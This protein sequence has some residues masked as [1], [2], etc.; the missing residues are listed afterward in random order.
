MK[1]SAATAADAGL[2]AARSRERVEVTRAQVRRGP[3][4]LRRRG[5]PAAPRAALHV[6]RRR[7][8]SRARRTR[9]R[10]AARPAADA[11]RRRRAG[12]LWRARD[13]VPCRCPEADG[14]QDQLLLFVSRAPRR[15][16]GGPSSPSGISAGPSTMRWTRRR[17]G[18]RAD[19][20]RGRVVLARGA[21]AML[22]RG[23]R[24]QRRRAGACSR[25]SGRSIFPREA[26]E[27]VIDGVAMDLDATRYQTF[28]DLFEYCRRVASAVGSICIR[29]F[30]CESAAASE[31]ALNLGV[32]LQLTNIIRDVKDDLARGRVYLPLEDLD[33][34]GCTVA[35]LDRGV[36]TDRVRELL[37]FECTRARE[38]YRRAVDVRPESDRRR[39]VA[40]EIMRAVYF[41][42]LK[43]IER[44]GYDVFQRPRARAAASAGGHRAEGSG[45]GRM[46]L[47]RHRHRRR[48]R[49]TERGRPAGG[50][51]ARACSCSRRGRG[52]AGA[53]RRSRTARPA[54]SSTTAS[55]CCSGATPRRSRFC[56]RSARGD[57]VRLQPQLGVTMIDRAG[58]AIAARR[59]RRCRRRCTCW[60]ACS[61][62]TRSTGAIGSS[63]LRMA[64]PLRIARR[65][66]RRRSTAIAASP[67]ETVESWLVRN[68]QTDRLREMLWHPLALAALN[69]PPDVAA[70]PPFAR[71][72]AEMFGGASGD[73]RA[74]A[75]ALPT[76]PLHL[77]YAEPARDVHR[78][79]RRVSSAP[80]SR[81]GF[82][83]TGEQSPASTAAKSRGRP[84]RSSSR[85]RGLRFGEVCS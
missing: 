39:L 25:S 26:F 30:G 13:G 85:C 4:R 17:D 44:R 62:G 60:P 9:A 6:A 21:G 7:A 50:A 76:K 49:G 71:V 42:T 36:V 33:A 55:T 63:V 43:R 83:S 3:R 45:C 14:A 2:G 69:Q 53:R 58:P 31:Y 56:R 51:A 65:Q 22:R 28:D 32:A 73:P 24:R 70:A 81:R 11:R 48:V 40:A 68:G 66:L 34:H 59:V 16:S 46:T 72:L 19:R 37:A 12:L 75:I 27:D 54:S 79:A 15:T 10:H 52:W 18:G 78:A 41:E 29:I 23:R 35:D 61:N 77:M 64:A 80:A 8:D 84:T 67:G 1:P 82:R 47:R 38:F 5:R 74:A 20:S 57:H